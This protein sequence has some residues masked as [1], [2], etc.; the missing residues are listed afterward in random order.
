MSWN[1]NAVGTAENLAKALDSESA[2]LSGDSK[3]E[4]DAAKPNLQGLLAMNVSNYPRILRLDASG[5]ASTSQG[6]VTESTCNV[7]LVGL[8]AQLV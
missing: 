1:F 8:N 5:H 6:V 7:S 2:R 3:T 4:F